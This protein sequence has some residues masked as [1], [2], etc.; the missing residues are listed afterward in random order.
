MEEAIGNK[1]ADYLIKPV[2]PNQI[3]VIFYFNFTYLVVNAT[4][5]VHY[6]LFHFWRNLIKIQAYTLF[7]LKRPNRELGLGLEY[8]FNGITFNYNFYVKTVD[9]W[10]F[11]FSCT[12]SC[13]QLVCKILHSLSFSSH[14]LSLW[15][16]NES[17]NCSWTGYLHNMAR[18]GNKWLYHRRA[19]WSKQDSTCAPHSKRKE[20]Q[21]LIL[22]KISV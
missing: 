7:D 12:K 15:E 3:L 17:K 10:A 21:K 13:L 2:N 4:D 16:F 1:I 6:N 18:A 5:H 20:L 8:N 22:A 9:H 14:L 19:A 11:H